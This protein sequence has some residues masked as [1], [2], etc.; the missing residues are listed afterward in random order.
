MRC[1]RVA[2]AQFNSVAAILI[3]T[4][5]FACGTLLHAAPPQRPV[6]GSGE[7]PPDNQPK[8]MLWPEGAPGA[9]GNEVDDQAWVWVYAPSKEQASGA[10]VVVCPGGGYGHLA[11]GHEGHDVARWLN[12]LGVTAFVLKYRLGPRYNH[13]APL[14][15]AQRAIRLVRHRA[16][17]YGVDPERVGI[18]GFS[19]GGHLTSTVA[20]HFDEARK[21]SDPI[22]QQSA[23]PSF[24]VLG[25]PVITL[26]AP[27]SHSG[28]R[29]NLLGEN[30]DAS[31]VEALSND[32]QV[33]ADSPPAFLFHAQDDKAVPPQHSLL[34]YKALC[35]AGVPAELHIYERGSH[36]FGL[37]ENDAVL[38]TWT[39]RC[40]DWMRQHGWIK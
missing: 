40:A 38:N 15:D 2:L 37:A 35:E 31:L 9:K 25:Y 14:D 12:E 11:I 34:F 33:T 4:T 36:G 28:S 5:I 18:L 21:S 23:R 30:P 7:T 8:L 29:K 24:A 6:R 17:E 19:A 27:F 32:T 26:S 13:P 22:D 20:T 1:R 3:A 39:D 10:A 16:S